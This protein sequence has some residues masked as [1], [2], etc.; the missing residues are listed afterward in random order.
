MREASIKWWMIETGIHIWQNLFLIGYWKRKWKT[1][2]EATAKIA[3]IAEH[4]S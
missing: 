3:K 1:K 2:K 4:K